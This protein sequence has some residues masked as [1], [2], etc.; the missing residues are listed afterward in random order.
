MTAPNFT[1]VRGGQ[2]NQAGDDRALFLK[3]YGGEVFTAFDESNVF[4]TRHFVRSLTSGK[5]AS[6]PSIGGKTA[7]YHTPGTMSVG[8]PGNLAE[9]ILTVDDFLES[10]S[11]IAEIDQAMAHFDYRGPFS[12]ED[13]RAIARLYDAN[14]AR[15]GIQA[16]LT[17]ASRFA[18]TGDIYEAKTVGKIVTKANALTTVADL[19]AG[20][21]ELAINFDEKDVDEADRNFFIKPAQYALLAADNETISSDYGSVADQK[22]LRVPQLYTFNLVKTNNLPTTAVTG[23]YGDKYN[24]DARNVVG[25][26]MKPGA[27]GT[28]KVRDMSV[29]MTG[30]DYKVTHNATLVTSRL[31]VGHGKLRPE[32]AGVIRTATPA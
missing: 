13:G 30:N 17:T 10:A 32:L 25:L 27:V 16:A 12:K 2:I 20:M 9:T 24:V 28:V 3:T 11:S 29:G 18:G 15:V 22:T 23:T 19:K 4:G 14:V 26:A 8:T 21:L 5:S 31:L 1:L 7:Y 6:F